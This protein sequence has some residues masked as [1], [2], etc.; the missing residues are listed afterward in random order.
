MF[1]IIL[2]RIL[3]G[4]LRIR[5]RGGFPE[6]F[7]NLCAYRGIQI[8]GLK[9]EEGVLWL[10]VMAHAYPGMRDIARR[11]GVQM[12]ISEKHGLPFLFYRYRRRPGIPL[13]CVVFVG[14]LVFM[15]R[16]VWSVELT[17]LNTVDEAKIRAT[18][19]DLGLYVGAKITD[20]E[21]A[22][23]RVELLLQ[24]KEL[25]W[26]SINLHGSH[27]LV[28]LHEVE[29]TPEPAKT[30]IPADI[31]AKYD[32]R[33]ISMEVYEGTA[34]VEK[35]EAV[36]KGDILISGKVEYASGDT[37][38]KHA[39][40]KIVAETR[41]QFSESIP[42]KQV[43][44]RRTGKSV[45]RRALS[46]FGVKIPFYLGS[47]KGQYE[48]ES[49]VTPLILNGVRLPVEWGRGDYYFTH[50][51]EILLTP[52]EAKELALE[53]LKKRE[54]EAFGQSEIKEKREFVENHE[55]WVKVT[56]H[57]SCIENISVEENL[58]INQEN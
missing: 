7:L 32:G 42:L 13:G 41:H 36:L 48:L 47:V 40:G 55:E 51:V 17:G 22:P 35:G 49:K 33:I 9:R 37:A 25:A 28:E 20:I 11:T 2:M 1:F 10:H 8:W 3:R 16:F 31:R 23:M 26:A 4:T 30:D 34:M 46:M 50:Q 19:Q 6:R 18:L 58:L 24:H 44:T 57:Y 27:A 56:I 45:T 15:S 54:K 43:V 14:F 29:Q 52:G 38:Y 12:R 53:K 39:R 5:V 21:A